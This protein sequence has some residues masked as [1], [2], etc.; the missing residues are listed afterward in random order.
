MFSSISEIFIQF[1]SVVRRGNGFFLSS[2]YISK[3]FWEERVTH[4]SNGLNKSKWNKTKKKKILKKGEQKSQTGQIIKIK[5]M[6]W[7]EFHFCMMWNFKYV[8]SNIYIYVFEVSIDC[9]WYFTK[10]HSHRNPCGKIFN[11]LLFAAVTDCFC[12]LFYCIST[13]LIY[14][15][16][17]FFF[18]KAVWFRQYFCTRKI[19]FIVK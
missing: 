17:V 14:R 12:F 13:I 6:A 10:R 9:D 19:Y 8:L 3:Q 15:Q 16:Y 1:I 18:N 11:I 2:I 5:W 4:N 7:N